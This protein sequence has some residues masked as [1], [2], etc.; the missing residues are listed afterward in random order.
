M[1]ASL[2]VSARDDRFVRAAQL[3][4]FISWIGETVAR[5][6]FTL[7]LIVTDKNAAIG[8]SLNLSRQ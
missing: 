2:T 1:R 4:I 8:V 7:T 5:D 6:N 3:S